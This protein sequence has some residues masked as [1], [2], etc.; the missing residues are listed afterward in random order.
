VRNCRA[1]IASNGPDGLRLS[2]GQGGLVIAGSAGMVSAR[3]TE[4]SPQWV[5]ADLRKGRRA[6]VALPPL[7]LLSL[8]GPVGLSVSLRFASKLSINV[9]PKRA[10]TLWVHQA[11]ATIKS[12]SSTTT[13]ISKAR[14]SP[15]TSHLVFHVTAGILPVE[16]IL[17]ESSMRHRRRSA[18]STDRQSSTFDVAQRQG[19]AKPLFLSDIRDQSS[20]RKRKERTQVA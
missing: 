16:A 13:S 18:R 8:R 4:R 2:G 19:R 1:A 12:R 15:F 11:S 5:V 6:H 17:A 10:I 3:D 9:V 7:S 14:K 20:T